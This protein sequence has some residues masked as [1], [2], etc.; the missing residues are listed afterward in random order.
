MYYYY[1]IFE[2]DNFFNYFTKCLYGISY[3]AFLLPHRL[4]NTI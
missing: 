1:F 4:K 2:L 3:M